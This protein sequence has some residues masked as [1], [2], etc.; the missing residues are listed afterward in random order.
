MVSKTT[1]SGIQTV[2]YFRRNTV[3]NRRIPTL[4][5][6]RAEFVRA[7]ITELEANIG[8]GSDDDYEAS[9]VTSGSEDDH[10]QAVPQ[11]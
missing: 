7:L 4:T 10:N 11:G 9:T 8:P 2:N 1:P 6:H 5:R 3:E